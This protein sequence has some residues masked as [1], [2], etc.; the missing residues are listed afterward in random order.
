[1]R[2]CLRKGWLSRRAASGDLAVDRVD[3]DALV[4]QDAQAAA[5]RP[6]RVGSSEATTTRAMPASTI[7]SVQGGVRP[8][9]QHGSSDTYSV[10]AGGVLLAGGERH[11]L[12]VRLAGAGVEA[13]AD[14]AAALDD[15][16]AH[17]RVRRRLA[18]GRRRP[19]RWP[20]EVA[21]VAL[22]RP[23]SAIREVRKVR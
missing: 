17:E 9:W 15:D 21:R 10:R 19:A 12:G 2:A 14:H 20:A 23:L 11:A 22:C 8:S 3:L 4:A 6:S 7:A 5:A 13:L 16:G 1:M 18:R